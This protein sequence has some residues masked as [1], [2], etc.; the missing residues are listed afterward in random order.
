[1]RMLYDTTQRILAM[2]TMADLHLG[3]AH[4]ARVSSTAAFRHGVEGLGF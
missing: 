1:M 3:Y 4:W 2:K